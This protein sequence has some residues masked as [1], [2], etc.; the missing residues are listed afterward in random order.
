MTTS[1]DPLN[2]HVATHRVAKIVTPRSNDRDVA[3]CDALLSALATS[4][5]RSFALELAGTATERLFLVRGER[6]AVDGVLAQLANA[7][8]QC[9]FT[10]LSA[11]ADPAQRLMQGM[12]DETGDDDLS[13][14]VVTEAR[15]R[16]PLY[17]P[18][19]TAS[20]RERVTFEEFKRAADPMVTLLSAMDKLHPGET[21]LVQYAL[22]PMDDDWSKYWRGTY[23][24][25]S[26]RAKSTP[27]EMGNQLMAAGAA[28]AL[29]LGVMGM[30]LASIFKLSGWLW[31]AGLLLVGVGVLLIAL[32]L[33]RPS[34]PDAAFVKQKVNQSAFRVRLR[35]FVRAGTPSDAQ[36][37]TDRIKAAFRA[38]N[39][40]GGNGFV[41]ISATSHDPDDILIAP[42][43]F[44]AR[45]PLS[46]MVAP[47][48]QQPVLS[49]VELASLWHLPHASAALQN[50]AYTSSRRLLPAREFTTG[51]VHLGHS[52]MQGER[53]AVKLPRTALAGNIGFIAKTQSGKSNLMALLAAD[54]IASD[55]DATVIVLDPHRS[56][57]ERV[58]ALVPPARQ[59]Q[60]IYWSVADRDRPFG[61][62]LLDRKPRPGHSRALALASD[63]HVD[64]RISDVV[65]SFRKI[66]PD[67]WG[68]R[69]EDYFRGPMMTL[70]MANQALVDG[71][72]F[73]EWRQ[74]AF[75]LLVGNKA[76]I[77]SGQL[78]DQAMQMIERIVRG[79]HDLRPPR[80]PSHASQYT[81]FAAVISHYTEAQ[82]KLARQERDGRAA[83]LSAVARLYKTLCVDHAPERRAERG[84][85]LAARVHAVE[86]QMRP[87]QYTLLDVNPIL[88]SR[89]MR[90][91]ALS[92]IDLDKGRHIRDWWRDSFDKFLPGNANFL[93]Q[94]MTPVEKKLNRFA[95]SDIAR[96][97]FG[98]PES[99]ID[100]SS[101]VQNGGVLLIDL[102]AGVVGEETAALIGSVIL[103]WIATLVFALQE[104]A[105]TSAG[106]QPKPRRIF[107]IVD[108]F[109][110]V[111]GANYK[112]YLSELAKYGVQL[113]LGTQSL[114]ALQK[115][116][117]ELKADFLGNVTNLFV[118]RTA[119]EDAQVLAREFGIGDE[120]QL[121]VQPS[122]I[123]GL[124]DYACFAKV[125]SADGSPGVFRLDTRKVDAGDAQMREAIQQASRVQ[126][127]RNVDE[128]DR[129]IREAS[130]LQ[131]PPDVFNGNTFGRRGF[132]GANGPSVDVFARPQ[133]AAVPVSD[134]PY[135]DYAPTVDRL[136]DQATPPDAFID[137]LR[138]VEGEAEGQV[139][140][141]GSVRS[142]SY[143]ANTTTTPKAS[144]IVQLNTD[145]DLGILNAEP[146]DNGF[147]E[148]HAP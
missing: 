100:L 107:I 109:H 138:T 61:L 27:Q 69:M 28:G 124:P 11:D 9:E 126:F 67:N 78:D 26:D 80:R 112:K 62:N 32:R 22:S 76:Q 130:D 63:L 97:I 131:G 110:T 89:A 137:L 134:E 74:R 42:P 8:P 121:T 53:L 38:Y 108:E 16:E 40:P 54:V 98:Q 5:Q 39:L 83:F 102:A 58:A 3:A 148:A 139:M 82:E 129:W 37:L 115:I 106:V 44:W 123:I 86:G 95:M 145:A 136:D 29:G 117:P 88:G 92:G 127:G 147:G 73:I 105:G 132:A 113:C 70:A 18:I 120:N 20:A 104:V 90:T 93:Q 15:L 96:H 46:Y 7:Y 118:F 33:S 144:P 66:W 101:L 35:V 1:N 57:A 30:S 14:L 79:F 25:V 125:R 36:L 142:S 111:P 12:S 51:E 135:G 31:L 128:V 75:V 24:D 64:K 116:D 60:T 10:D 23:D 77:E 6:R 141:Q 65:D 133:A 21:C 17:L 122:D 34:A 91:T 48:L 52:A 55:P 59:A 99:T 56:M 72:D 87:L 114:E 49:T 45:L 94:M 41:F 50:V 143:A 103:N 47:A 19:K 140:G 4:H 2:A 71:A 43:N 84:E 119:A 68:P 146:D 81:I 85:G 13:S